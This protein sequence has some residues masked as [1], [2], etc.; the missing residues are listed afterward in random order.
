MSVIN[1]TKKTGTVPASVSAIVYDSRSVTP[2]SAF[3]AIRGAHYDGHAFIDDAIERGASLIVHDAEIPQTIKRNKKAGCFARVDDSRRAL[4]AAA[5]EFYGHPSRALR[6]IGVTGTD[7][8]STT[9]YFTHQ[10][11]EAAGVKSGFFST[12]AAQ[13]RDTVEP[14]TLRQSTPEAPAIHAALAEMLSAGKTAAVLE[15]TSHGLSLKTARLADVGFYGAVFTNLTHEHIE[16]HGSFEAYR[17]DKSNLFRAMDADQRSGAFGVVNADDPN[18]EHFG[19]LTKRR[20]MTYGTELGGDLTAGM[21]E[22]DMTGTAFVL[23]FGE[24]S[25][26]TRIPV[27]GV[28]NVENALAALAA[29]ACLLDVDPIEL[30]PYLERLQPVEG[31]M[32][33]IGAVDLPINVIVDYAHTPG[34]FR[35][36]FPII[37]DYTKGRVIAVFGS[38]GERDVEKRPM[39]GRIAA[40]WSDIIVL[41]D[42]DPRDESRLAI[43]NQIAEGCR[44]S[45][46]EW[47]DGVELATIPDRSEAIHRAV[48]I[49]KPGDTV[50]LLG[51]GHEKSLITPMGSQPWNEAQ[52]ARAALRAA[53]YPVDGE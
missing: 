27:V 20:V 39:Q 14:N 15:A 35:R 12:V 18:A 10:L 44:E 32:A 1:P 9:V 48:K 3:V 30:A 16:F 52:V 19:G 6:V 45:R 37:R 53:G 22:P 42:E 36:L 34:S 23:R 5:A 31:R 17:N 51:K 29:A 28:F 26:H 50:L 24:H 47:R 8:K 46:P 21:L 4:S 2:G 7:G 11:L 13:T 38:A 43:L 41:T 25:I 33:R 49:A 40:Q